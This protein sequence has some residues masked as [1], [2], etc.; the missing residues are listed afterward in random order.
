ME[1]N[2]RDI[3]VSVISNDTEQTT[4]TQEEI[5]RSRQGREADDGYS[6]ITLS[7]SSVVFPVSSSYLAL[8]HRRWS[9]HRQHQVWDFSE[10]V[11]VSVWVMVHLY[12]RPLSSPAVK[13]VKGWLGG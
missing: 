2:E 12:R 10:D 9:P 7:P 3:I 6:V 5:P 13:G 11:P 1:S 4:E 8:L